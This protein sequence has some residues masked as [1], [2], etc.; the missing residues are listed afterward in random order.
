MNSPV[1]YRVTDRNMPPKMSTEEIFQS[2]EGGLAPVLAEYSLTGK[3]IGI[4]VGSRGIRSL[5]EIVTCLIQVLQTNGAE[6]VLLPAMG[7]HGGATAEGQQT[8]LEEYGL[9]QKITGVPILS[10]MDV[11]QVGDVDEHPVYVDSL[12]LGLDGVIP[13]NRIKAHTDFHGVYESGIA[14]MLV[15]GAGKRHQAEAVHQHG[16]KGLTD[17]IPKIAEIVLKKIP[18]LAAVAILENKF[19]ETALIEVL[20]KT[21]VLSREQE[22]LIQSK[23]MLPIIPFKDLDVLVVSQMGKN[24][25]GVGMDPNITKRMRIGGIEEEQG[26]PR[27]IVVL[28]LTEASS[29]NSL[30]MG[31]AD[32]ITQKLYDKVDFKKTYINTITSGFLER[33]FVPVVMPTE[34]EAISVAIQTCGRIATWET[35]RMV[36]IYNTLEMAEFFISAPLLTEL[37]THYIAEK[38]AAPKIFDDL[39]ALTLKWSKLP[40]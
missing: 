5:Q 24:I 11:T 27:R 34:Q 1:L 6:V 28:D 15:I 20:N 33:C 8:I 39:G 25:S 19:D 29:G 30:G 14:K 37:P 3:K 36:F 13:V 31:I 2:I 16:T 17:L 21:N 12:V 4:L 40:T 10:C 18:F 35:A 38:T 26:G 9:G 7:S 22:L 32:V 23:K